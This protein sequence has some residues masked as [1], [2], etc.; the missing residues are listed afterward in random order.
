MTFYSPT[1]RKDVNSMQM[2]EITKY[3]YFDLEKK[4]RY[5]HLLLAM[6][7]ILL[8][9]KV[10][11]SDASFVNTNTDIA[12]TRALHSLH[13]AFCKQLHANANILGELQ[14]KS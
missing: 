2:W 3:K 1:M 6:V 11:E 4:Y 14:E 8:K 10:S 7:I 13:P 9:Y 12:Q 5:L